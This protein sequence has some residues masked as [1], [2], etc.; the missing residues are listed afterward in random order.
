MSPS[1]ITSQG[2]SDVE[3]GGDR[4]NPVNRHTRPAGVSLTVRPVHTRGDR[5]APEGLDGD[6]DRNVRHRPCSGAIPSRR[7]RMG[8]MHGR[9]SARVMPSTVP[10]SQVRRRHRP[11]YGQTR[12]I[13]TGS[14]RI[15]TA[16][17]ARASGH[18]GTRRPSSGR[19]GVPDAIAA[20]SKLTD[21]TAC[22]P[23]CGVLVRQGS[24]PYGDACTCAHQPMTNGQQPGRSTAVARGR[25]MRARVQPGLGA[26]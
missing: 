26:D 12:V 2:T 1:A 21:P 19:A 5:G 17:H 8:S 6:F 20:L 25:I 15:V 14:T 18:P 9:S 24:G 22:G 11:Y 13:P 16:S 7:S 4:P 23:S 10:R 3:G